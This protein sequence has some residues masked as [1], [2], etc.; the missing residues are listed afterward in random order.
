MVRRTTES[1]HEVDFCARVATD[2]EQN[3]AT[4]R[5][6]FPFTHVRVEGFGTGES[7]RK[8]KDLRF[9]E[10]N[11][12]LALCGEVK[13]PGSAEGRSPF[14]TEVVSDAYRKAEDANVQ[15]FFTWKPIESFF[16][17]RSAPGS[18]SSHAWS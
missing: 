10:L 13:L 9:Y 1:I 4:D 15:Y 3:F 12:K 6:S 14:E 7:R 16:T 17:R 5:A 18:R 11:N 2:A 8:R